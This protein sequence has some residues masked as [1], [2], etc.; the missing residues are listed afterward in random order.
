[1]I[2]SGI[3]KWLIMLVLFKKNYS[4][5]YGLA[6]SISEITE[7]KLEA[8]RRAIY[9][10]LHDLEKAGF[11]S[12]KSELKLT[13]KGRNTILCLLKLQ[14]YLENTEL[15]IIPHELAEILKRLSL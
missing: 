11:V 10:N 4:T 15:N 5:I 12:S 6:K 8:A 14:K 13:E 9:R 1:M 7:E 2:K 3:R